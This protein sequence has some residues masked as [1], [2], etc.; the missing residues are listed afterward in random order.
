MRCKLVLASTVHLAEVIVSPGTNNWL[1]ISRRVQSQY[2]LSFFLCFF[3]FFN[4]R[5]S[6][7]T[8][9]Q[10]W[11]SAAPS[12][13]LQL[14]VQIQARETKPWIFAEAQR[15]C[16]LLTKKELMI[17][18]HVLNHCLIIFCSISIDKKNSSCTGICHT[19]LN[20]EQK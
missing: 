14:P 4:R 7:Q 2:F 11:Q 9:Y 18:G 15:I 1:Y 12:Y 13:C 5:H 19:M 10:C 17:S 16:P 6:T 3:F 20:Q 8:H